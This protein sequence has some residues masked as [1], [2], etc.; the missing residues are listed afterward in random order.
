MPTYFAQT[1]TCAGLALQVHIFSVC[2][3]KALSLVEHTKTRCAVKCSVGA[4]GGNG[5]PQLVACP[6]ELDEAYLESGVG[7]RE[8]QNTP[9]FDSW[10]H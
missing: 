10:P 8:S 4:S 6:A 9:A 2:P 7:K 5:Q 3:Q 1:A